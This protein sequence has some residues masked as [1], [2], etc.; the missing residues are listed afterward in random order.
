MRAGDIELVLKQIGQG[1]HAGAAGLDNVCCVLG[2]AAA[3]TKQANANGG[4][5]TC[6]KYCF[7]LHQHEAYC[8]SGTFEKSPAIEL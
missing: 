2:A 1:D 8:G 5:G 3:T 6:A 4:V 7:R